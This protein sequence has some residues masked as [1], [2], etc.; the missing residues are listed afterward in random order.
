MSSRGKPRYSRSRS[1][2]PRYARRHS[3]SRSKSKSPIRNRVN[4]R[5]S[6]SRSPL[7]TRRHHVGSRESPEENNCLAVF[8]L[9]FST[10]QRYVE[11]EFSKFGP[12]EKVDLPMDGHSCRS[13]GFAF[14]YFENLRDARIAREEM[15]DRII[16]GRKVRVD[17]SI[18]KRAHTP[19]PGYYMGHKRSSGDGGYRGDTSR[20]DRRRQNEYRGSRRDSY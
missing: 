9:S 18:H 1:S 8:G 11:R 2:S 20:Y 16:D 15:C 12:L 4:K 19:T 14:V 7:P 5:R 10:T 3:R 6:Y 17:Y 13:R